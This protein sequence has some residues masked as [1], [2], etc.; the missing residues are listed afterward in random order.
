[1]A[2]N[3]DL[4]LSGTIIEGE[5]VRINNDQTASASQSV[6][7]QSTNFVIRGAGQIGASSL[8]GSELTMQD[9]S[10]T[11][12]SNSSL[13]RAG[14]FSYGDSSG[15]ATIGKVTVRRG[16]ILNYV[17]GDT[18]Q[19]FTE[20]ADTRYMNISPN[21]RHLL[22]FQDGGVFKD[23]TATFSGVG[24]VELHGLVD[25]SGN[26]LTNLTGGFINFSTNQ[27]LTIE[28]QNFLGAI[29]TISFTNA[30]K[31]IMT[32]C[33]KNG[34]PFTES[35]LKGANYVS[36]V[37][38][39]SE[40]TAFAKRQKFT[41]ADNEGV[42]LTGA[43]TAYY[44]NGASI[45]STTSGSVDRLAELFRT[46]EIQ[47]NWSGAVLSNFTDFI[48]A[49]SPI[50][51]R[52][53]LYGYL[54]QEAVYA[55]YDTYT[56]HKDDFV[57][58]QEDK[59]LVELDKATVDARTTISTN[60]E[61]YEAAQSFLAD[62]MATSAITL[63]SPTG[64]AGAYAIKVD[65][66]ASSV[67]SLSGNTI[68]FK[69]DVFIGNITTT[70]TFTLANGATVLGTVTDVSGTIRATSITITDLTSAAIY[71]EDSLGVQF[72]YQTGV[73]GTYNNTAPLGSSGTWKVII[74]RAGYIASVNTFTADGSPKSYNGDLAQLTQPSGSPMYTGSSSA[75]LSVVPVADGSQMSVRIGN[76]IVTA[77]QVLDE[78]EG[79]LSTVAGMK[80]L[81]NGGGRIE[82]A[83]LATGTFLFLKSNVRL[84]RDTVTDSSATV[85]AFVTSSDGIITDNVNGDVQFVT[86]T[87]AQQL[88]EYDHAIYIDAVT[89][90]NSNIYPFGTEANPVDSW[91]NAKVLAEFYGFRNIR[92][93]GSLTLDADMEGYLLEGGGIL[94]H[95]NTST[96]SVQGSTFTRMNMGGSGSGF[97]ACDTV[98]L[99]NGVTNLSGTFTLC[100]LNEQFSLSDNGSTT[101]SR[102]ISNLAGIA[103]PQMNL[104]VNTQTS[105]RD[106]DGSL[107]VSGSTVGC[108]TSID[109]TSGTAILDNTNTGGV[110]VLGG[111][112]KTAI[113]DNSSGTTINT[114]GCFENEIMR[115][116]DLTAVRAEVDQ[117]L[118]D[119]DVDTKTNVKPSV[120]V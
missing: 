77:Q 79:V 90:V 51:R 119:Y 52:I 48:S 108:N 87:R 68:T 113:T 13:G 14:V 46:N 73:S 93:K 10:V 60:T 45:Y 33:L 81:A 27:S 105:L 116:T 66:T 23:C 112:P 101:F 103:S 53:R 17:S 61:L 69:S 88:I 102:C 56:T 42:A 3:N 94:D 39:S 120:S 41:I 40:H 31:N 67:F 110:I 5:I 109:Y 92:F 11:I 24:I 44:Q 106:Y 78:S 118:V 95:L 65:K 64:D 97:R 55:S 25:I 18:D 96:F 115:G 6:V 114:E 85:E 4:A 30:G 62:N 107:V 1:M 91:S 104:G 16:H 28:A 84:V 99:L 21:G 36:L 100:A 12:S 43:T 38:T 19:F 111:I 74:N 86:V 89:G 32:D 35:E 80:Y 72:D 9:C 37:N 71:I 2:T 117:A 47:Q 75:L 29:G 7:A 34:A 15:I 76:G 70:D 20:L 57:K 58:L 82:S 98:N 49:A 59:D 83:T 8:T 54:P 63:I 26:S 22:R 50:S